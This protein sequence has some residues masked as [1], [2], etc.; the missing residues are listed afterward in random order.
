MKK[1]F[2]LIPAGAVL[3]FLALAAVPIWGTDSDFDVTQGG[4]QFVNTGNIL[5]KAA[6][7]WINWIV[8]IL[9]GLAI[10]VFFWGIVKYIASG[11][12]EE[13]RKAGRGFM[14]YGI[15]GLFVMVSV[16]GLVYLLASLL[17][18][19]PGGGVDLP[20]VPSINAGG[21]I[22]GGGGGGSAGS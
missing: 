7:K 12:D 2:K 17:G 15:I 19:R 1:L 14:I 3:P 18:I 5:I 13:G 20:G 6:S 22:N 16:W 11:G 21:T 8:A 9:M 10:L 4:G